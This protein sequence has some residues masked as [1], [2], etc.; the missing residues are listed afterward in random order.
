MPKPP[1]DMV[2]SRPGVAHKVDYGMP[3]AELAP[4]LGGFHS[5]HTRI[6]PGLHHEEM[7]MPAWTAIRVQTYGN[8]W[9]MRVGGK[10]F[11]PVPRLALFGPSTYAGTATVSTGHIIGTYLLPRAWARLIKSPAHSYANRIVPM[12]EVLGEDAL[13]LGRRLQAAEGFENQVADFEAVLLAR[14]HRCPPEP[15]EIAAIE[16]ILLD[17]E[18]NT[19]EDATCN[20]GMPNWQFARFVKQHFGFTPKVLMRRARFMRTILKIRETMDQSWA[21]LVDEA[22]TDQS[23]FIRDC[24]DFLDMTPGQFAARYQP[25]AHAAFTTRANVFGNRHHLLPEGDD[26]A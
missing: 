11:D 1:E 7:F 18:V 2:E 13:E 3:G 14:L 16:A 5:F 20:L 9:S 6:D 12:E 17:P 10:N 22:Y 21:T 8:D 26:R 15:P 4:Y 24:R 23:H 25:I 19:V